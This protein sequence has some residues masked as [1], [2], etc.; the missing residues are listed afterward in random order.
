MTVPTV[1]LPS[2]LKAPLYFLICSV[3]LVTSAC[4][5]VVGDTPTDTR[6]PGSGG[7][8]PSTTAAARRCFDAS[9][10]TDNVDTGALSTDALHL[11]GERFTCSDD[12]VVVGSRNLGEMAGAAQL[13]AALGAPLLFPHPQLTAELGRLKPV[14]IHAIGEVEVTAPP[15][16]RVETYDIAAAASLTASTLGGTAIS[17]ASVDGGA[18]FIVDV[19]KAIQTGDRVVVDPQSDP[20]SGSQPVREVDPIALIQGLAV[21]NQGPQVWLVPAASPEHLLLAAAAAAHLG[22]AVIAVDAGDLLAHPEVS[23]SLVGHSSESVRFIGS[24]PALNSWHVDILANADEV[25]GGGFLI[26]PPD[27]PRR[28]VAFYGHPETEALGALGEQGPLATLER[29]R[30]FLE[31]YTGDGSQVVPVF[32]MI[33]SVAAAGATDDGDYSFEWPISTFEDWISTARE[34][35][36]YV[37]LDLQPGREDFLSQARQYEE[38][39]KLPFVGLAL[40]PEWRLKPDQVHLR[41]VG[42]VSA[43]EVNQVIH[44]LADL[45]KDNGLPQKML[46]VHQFRTMM[47]QDRELLEE[48]PEIQ[49]IIQMDGDGTEPQKDTTYAALNAGAENAFW[50]WGWKNFFDEDEPGPPS[51]QSTMSKEPTPVYVSYQ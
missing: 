36:V 14:R 5:S 18:E 49:L 34:E 27:Q 6:E 12:V 16:A 2:T 19:L 51:P 25:P 23:V 28:Y 48:R 31:A 40:D 8:A 7:Q 11:A 24:S 42:S 38:L 39:L 15:D 32:E 29:M 33:A 46:I 21:P 17:E 9:L 1:T 26:L 30:P 13:A 3:L 47:I 37:I 43:H 41:Q 44:W 22:V 45:V 35:G 10:R 50:A 20:T 4:S